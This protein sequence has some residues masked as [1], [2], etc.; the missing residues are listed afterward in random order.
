M[1]AFQCFS[2]SAFCLL[3]FAGCSPS[4]DEA[5]LVLQQRIA[6]ESQGH[7]K[8]VSFS[9][10]ELQEFQAKGVAGRRLSY[11]ADIEFDANGVWSRW[12]DNPT[13]LN[14]EFAAVGRMWA[15][16]AGTITSDLQGNRVMSK[17]DRIKIA[18]V[19]TGTKSEQGW[20]YELNES[21]T[22]D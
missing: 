14:F 10:T 2:L 22:T 4:L 13:H 3:L 5:K 17:G 9:K 20:N 7:I 12:A 1:S 15:G 6:T 11:A 19:M 8:L 16:T 21:R 18:G